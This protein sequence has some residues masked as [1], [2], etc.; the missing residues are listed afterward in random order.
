MVIQRWQSL[1]LLVASVVMACFTFCQIGQVQ[2]TDFTFSFTSM[3]FSYEGEATD[4]APSGTFLSTWYFFILSLTTTVLLLIDIFLYKNLSFQKKICLVSILMIIATGFAG[5]CLGYNAIE[6][7]TIDWTE[8][9]IAP[10]ISLFA[11]ILAYSRMNSDQK[12]LRAADRIR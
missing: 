7:G 10:F 2:T 11:A 8:M 4:G 3:G 6:G 5:G 12:K 1:L 9:A